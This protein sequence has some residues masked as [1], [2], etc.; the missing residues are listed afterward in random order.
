[1]LPYVKKQELNNVL[2]FLKMYLLNMG[3]IL[4]PNCTCTPSLNFEK[5]VV[6]EPLLKKIAI[7][8]ITL[9]DLLRTSVCAEEYVY[10]TKSSTITKNYQAELTTQGLTESTLRTNCSCSR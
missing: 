8:P 10:F 9:S 7:H 2:Y 6:A 5:F 4:I 3:I 1:M